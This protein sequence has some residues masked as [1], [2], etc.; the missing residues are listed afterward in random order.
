MNT[1]LLRLCF[2]LILATFALAAAHADTNAKKN[3]WII[4]P[5]EDAAVVGRATSEPP[6]PTASGSKR[7]AESPAT[8]GWATD[9]AAACQRAAA[10][11]KQV[12]LNFTG[13]DWCTWCHKLEA[14]VFSK[15]DFS[16]RAAERYVLVTVDFPQKKKLPAA[17][18]AQNNR[19]KSDF[20]V[21]G[22][23]TIVVV[24]PEGRKRAEIVGYLAGGPKVFFAALDRQT[25][26]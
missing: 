1:S 24:S 20:G 16:S 12:L 13:S 7:P 3:P 18:A 2:C 10:E 22:Y 14:E 8:A 17:E 19:L 11:N 9:Y 6:P 25:K 4:P 21:R 15:P 5:N 23:P 26:N